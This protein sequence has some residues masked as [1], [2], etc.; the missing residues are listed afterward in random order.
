MTKISDSELILNPD[1]SIYH[2]HLQPDQIGQTIITVGDQDRVEMVS[3]YFDR[4]DTKVQKREFRTHTGEL[5][6]KRITVISTGI[7]PD[8]IDIVLNELDA[9]VNIDFATRQVKETETSLDIIRIGTSGCLQEDIPVDSILI[10]EQAIGLDGLMHFYEFY[11][12]ADET[13][14]QHVFLRAM[15]QKANFPIRPYF[16]QGNAKLIQKIGYDMHKGTTVT[17]PGFYAPQGRQLRAAITVGGMLDALAEFDYDG[18]RITNF[19]M[20]TA[21]IYG[22][23]RLLGHNAVSCNALLANRA[24]GTF[25]ENPKRT[26]EK[27]IE[28]VLERL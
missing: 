11:N 14:F 17:C 20:E 27:L 6:G 19:E 5:N 13:M 10:S 28:V 21:A 9:L 25:S 26:M 8:N 18:K 15:D 4:I 16:I 1:Q 3:K 22:M 7:G 24:N 23:S 12:N 2:L